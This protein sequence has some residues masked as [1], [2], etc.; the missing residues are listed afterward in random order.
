MDAKMFDRSWMSKARIMAGLSQREAAEACGISIGFYSK[1]ENG[2]Q[3][4]TVKTALVISDVLGVDVRNFL[5]ERQI[6]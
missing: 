5:N 3:T 1:I 6:V 2:L 4:P